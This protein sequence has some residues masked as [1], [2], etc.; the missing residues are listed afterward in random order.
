MKEL[1]MLGKLQREYDAMEP[2]DY[3][4]EDWEEPEYFDEPD[5]YE[6]YSDCDEPLSFRESMYNSFY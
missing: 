1:D 3:D 2:E 4:D 5:G 6:D